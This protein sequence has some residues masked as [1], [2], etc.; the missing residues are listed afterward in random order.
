[1]KRI[2]L[3]KDIQPLSAFRANAASIIQQVKEEH[4]PVV[5]TQHGKGAAVLLD[6][7]DYEEMVDTIEMLKEVSQARRELDQ[8]KGVP[9]EDAM[10]SARERLKSLR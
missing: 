4:R 5:I 8:G 10:K 7:A 1:M 3:D 9:H 2:K 6:I